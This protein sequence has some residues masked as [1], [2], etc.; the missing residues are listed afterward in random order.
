[1][2]ACFIYIRTRGCGCTWHP[3]FPAPFSIGRTRNS[4]KNSGAWRREIAETRLPMTGWLFEDCINALDVVPA[5][6]PGPITTDVRVARYWS[7]NPITT[8]FCGF[9]S[10]LSQGRRILGCLKCESRVLC[11]ARSASVG[12]H[13][14]V[15]FVF[16]QSRVEEVIHGPSLLLHEV[17]DE[18]AV[19]RIAAVP[20]AHRDIDGPLAEGVAEVLERLAVFNPDVIGKAFPHPCWDVTMVEAVLDFDHMRQLV[21]AIIGERPGPRRD[22]AVVDQAAGVEIGAAQEH[23]AEAP[24]GEAVGVL[25]GQEEQ[26]MSPLVVGDVDAILPP[27]S[28]QWRPGQ[29]RLAVMKQPVAAGVRNRAIG[30]D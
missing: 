24:I 29:Q 1:M 10:L 21:P 30:S 20:H 13:N 19:A 8:N 15:R 14:R 26:A 11:A 23:R 5:S 6:A 28:R 2:L 22:I 16:G 4:C 3:A 18:Q 27:L 9:G 12:A 25:V 17:G 7:G